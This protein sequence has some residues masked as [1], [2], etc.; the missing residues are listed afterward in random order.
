MR[1]VLLKLKRNIKV[2]NFKIRS[3]GKYKFQETMEG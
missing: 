3:S 2:G 1:K